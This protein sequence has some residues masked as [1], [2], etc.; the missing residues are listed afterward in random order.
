MSNKGGRFLV[1]AEANIA[2]VFRIFDSFSEED[3]KAT[4]G[5]ISWFQ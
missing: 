5:Q 3:P 4:G 1:S 2:L